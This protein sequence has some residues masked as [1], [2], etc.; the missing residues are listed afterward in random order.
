MGQLINETGPREG[1]SR[2]LKSEENQQDE[3]PVTYGDFFD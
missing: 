1:N 2:L 3:V